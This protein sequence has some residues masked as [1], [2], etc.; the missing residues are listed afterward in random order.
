[1]SLAA[2]KDEQ[3]NWEEM[4]EKSS[5]AQLYYV[6]VANIQVMHV[7]FRSIKGYIS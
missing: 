2:Y 1:M 3:L 5:V 6:S 4:R 7:P